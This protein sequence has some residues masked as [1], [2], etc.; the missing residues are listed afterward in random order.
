MEITSA[1]L[2]NHYKQLQTKIADKSVSAEEAVKSYVS[3]RDEMA[4]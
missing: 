1:S 3:A 4:R 2:I